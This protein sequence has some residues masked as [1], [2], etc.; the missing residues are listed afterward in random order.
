MKTGQNWQV[1]D[2]DERD[3]ENILSLRKVVFGETEEDK[4]DPNF[5]R[6]QFMEG[7]DGKALIHIAEDGGRVIGHFADVPRRFSANGSMVLGTLSIDL[8]VHPD[9]RRRGIFS[10]LGRLAIERVK[11]GN[12]LFMM[13]YPIR[14]ETIQGFKKIGWEVVTEL[15]VIVCPIRFQGIVHRYLPIP[16]ISHFLGGVARLFYFILYWKKERGRVEGIEIEEVKEFDEQFDSFWAK[17]LSLYPI[18]GVR[19]R[20]YLTWRYLRHPTRT[21]I[22]FRAKKNGE[23]KGYIILRKVDLL[24]FK[25]A[26]IVDL[27]AIDNEALSALMQK[28]IDQSR[29]EKVDLLGYMVPQGHSYYRIL[30]KRG[31]LLSLKTFL[32]MLYPQSSQEVLLSPQR[33]YVNW[34]DTDVI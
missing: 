33:W 12:G 29:E 19:D 1:R 32:L 24:G 25:S 14:K 21:Y 31:F 34:G 23:M 6:W 8:M 17:A 10:E 26:V 18:L 16:I 3:L 7:P 4:V 13:A 27:I 11:K 15:P 30:R 28:G 22:I 5:W 9:Y 20:N 2:G